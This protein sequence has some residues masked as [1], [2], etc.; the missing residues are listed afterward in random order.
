MMYGAQEVGNRPL[1]VLDGLGTTAIYWSQVT[2]ITWRSNLRVR[3]V[4]IHIH[5]AASAGPIL[6]M[7]HPHYNLVSSAAAAAATA[8]TAA[9]TTTSGGSWS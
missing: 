6:D 8:L 9:A 5:P 7:A 3:P 4:S 2:M 1:S